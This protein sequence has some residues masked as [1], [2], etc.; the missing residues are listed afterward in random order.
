[1]DFRKDL[2]SVSD[3]FLE[4]IAKVLKFQEIVYFLKTL[5]VSQQSILSWVWLY[6]FF[7]SFILQ[8]TYVVSFLHIIYVVM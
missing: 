4:E 3:G 8:T 5:F 2:L 6:L 7:L 1:M